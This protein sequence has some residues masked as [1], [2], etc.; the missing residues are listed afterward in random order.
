LWTEGPD[1]GWII[2]S[3]TECSQS[4]S[5]LFVPITMHIFEDTVLLPP[6]ADWLLDI[7]PLN[8]RN[9]AI[10][11]LAVTTNFYTSA[12]LNNLRHHNTAPSFLRPAAKSFCVNT[13]PA[14][15]LIPTHL[16]WN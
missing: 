6:C 7:D 2:P 13:D 8:A 11:N 3:L 15:T 4:S 1:G 9:N 16:A 5:E 14:G 10:T 12:F